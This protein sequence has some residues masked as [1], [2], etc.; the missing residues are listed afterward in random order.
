R[1]ARRTIAALGYNEC[2]TYSF[3]DAKAAALFGGGTEAVRIE[4]PISS[5]MTH[6]RPDLL[7]GLL[8]AAAR[9]QARG[10]MDLA[11]FEI[12]PVFHGGEPGDQHLQASGLLVGAAAGRDPHGSRRMID[13]FD[14]KADAEAVLAALGAP[15]RVQITRKAAQWWHPGRS[16]VIGLGPNTMATFGEVH[17][18]ILQAMDAKGPAVAFTLLVANV[19]AP[20][21]KTPTRPALAISDLQAVDRDFAFVVDARVEA[22][23]AVNAAQGADKVLIDSVRV[24]DQFT[25]DKA[26]AQMGP[27]KKSIALTVRLQPQDKT[28]TE[29]EIEAVSAKI[30]EKVTKAT[31]GSLRA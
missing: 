2:V 18:R 3:I 10:F 15:A 1:T 17:P 24:F 13:V 26:E 30:I 12:G 8:A 25:G 27:G 31:G 16:G 5:E 14:A 19:P 29:A 28:L 23:T 4:N 7:P 11:L 22:L 9:N 21:V 20:K 6:L